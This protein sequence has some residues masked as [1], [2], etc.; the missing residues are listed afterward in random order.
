MVAVLLLAAVLVAA[1][2]AAV[3][4]PPAL[5]LLAAAQLV[6]LSAAHGCSRCDSLAYRGS[7]FPPFSCA[8]SLPVSLLPA[9]F[10][11]RLFPSSAALRAVVSL[12]PVVADRRFQPA[13]THYR[14][15]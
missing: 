12:T 9:V 11:P 4:A 10:L 6:A 1:A 3:A 2:A 15:R 5:P 13:M 7:S 14:H 8:P